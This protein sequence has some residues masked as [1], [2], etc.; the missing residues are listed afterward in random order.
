MNDPIFV[1]KDLNGDYDIHHVPASLII[2]LRNNYPEINRAFLEY[3]SSTKPD[4]IGSVVRQDGVTYARMIGG[5]YNIQI[6]R[7][8]QPDW[9]KDWEQLA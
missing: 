8:G 5:W 2:P 4:K 3:I 6:D 9:M 7:Y 1:S